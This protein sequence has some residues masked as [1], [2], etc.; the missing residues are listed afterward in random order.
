MDSKAD[1]SAAW[2][3]YQFSFLAPQTQT[4]EN[5]IMHFTY[6]SSCSS[7]II[8]TVFSYKSACYPLDFFYAS[9]K[10]QEWNQTEVFIL[11]RMNGAHPQGLS[12]KQERCCGE[13]VEDS[14]YTMVFES[15]YKNEM[16]LFSRLS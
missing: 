13:S 1:L 11:K 15:K 10:R 6:H 3:E 2:W 14:F 16:S 9:K 7:T 5:D 8:S 12:N 4:K